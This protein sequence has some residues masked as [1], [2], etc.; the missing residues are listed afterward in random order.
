MIDEY[1]KLMKISFVILSSVAVV[2]C[3]PS[4]S[5]ITMKDMYA[6][7][8]IDSKGS[9]EKSYMT[10]SDKMISI[11][12]NSKM[13]DSLPVRRVI[14]DMSRSNTAMFIVPVDEKRASETIDPNNTSDIALAF[15]IAKDHVNL[16]GEGS[17]DHLMRVTSENNNYKKFD[18]R[19]CPQ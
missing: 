18:L 15:A 4:A 3:S 1:S 12:K 2:S 19:R 17:P 6:S 7:R 5:G 13:Y 11:V 9:C 16:I 14:D 8:W 10:F